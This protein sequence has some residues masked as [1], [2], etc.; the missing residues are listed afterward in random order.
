M[1][2]N[3][4]DMNKEDQVQRMAYL[5]PMLDDDEDTDPELEKMFIQHQLMLR[6]KMNRLNKKKSKKKHQMMQSTD[7]LY[8]VN[9]H[10]IAPSQVP[11]NDTAKLHFGRKYDEGYIEEQALLDSGSS[12][13]TVTP[14]QAEKLIQSTEWTITKG[15]MNFKV[16]NGGQKEETFTGDH[17]KIPVRVIGTKQFANVKFFIMPHNKC[18]FN[19]ILGLRDMKRIGYDIAAR[20]GDDVLIFKNSGRKIKPKYLESKEDILDKVEQMGDEFACYTLFNKTKDHLYHM[21]YS[22]HE[23]HGVEKDDEKEDGRI[24][25]HQL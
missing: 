8:D 3:R 24:P 17:I 7:I 11:D 12:I 13:S 25:S 16:E 18:T 10:G 1:L 9:Y 22:H 19:V 4:D 21:N 5:R 20:V 2:Q 23:S 15:T 6:A 14:H